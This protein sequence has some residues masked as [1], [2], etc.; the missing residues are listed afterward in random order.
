MKIAFYTN[1][2]K[3][4]QLKHTCEL[5]EHISGK[6]SQIIV[7]DKHKFLIPKELHPLVNFE[8]NIWQNADF[9][10]ALGGDGTMLRAAK[11]ANCPILGLNL[12]NLGYLTDSNI[13]LSF[14][15]I[16][17]LFAND[18]FVENRMMLQYEH[19]NKQHLALNDVVIYRGLSTKLFECVIHINGEFM[20]QIRADGIIAASPTGST[21]YNLSAGGPIL[22]PD[23]KMIAITPISSH[24]LTSRPAIISHKDE[25]T[26]T[27]LNHPGFSL[28]LD[29]ETIPINI[30]EKETTIRIKKA[31]K[32]AHI[33]KTNSLSFYETLRNKMFSQKF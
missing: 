8:A 24:S 16:N 31:D 17:K 23:A 7:D 25:L 12:G 27:F 19:L 22:K 28:A 1:I 2:K 20:T 29:G 4:N 6:V 11:M 18:Y 33:L 5:I 10:I 32:T 3:D 30:G 13:D 15:A 21:A 14:P 26:I 9:V